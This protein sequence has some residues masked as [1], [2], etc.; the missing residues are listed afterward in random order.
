[1]LIMGNVMYNISVVKLPV[2]RV[3]LLVIK[4][5]ILS[6]MLLLIFGFA[7]TI[8]QEYSIDLTSIVGI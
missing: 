8:L 4:D 3:K 1:M 7:Q 5:V 2:Y 6:M